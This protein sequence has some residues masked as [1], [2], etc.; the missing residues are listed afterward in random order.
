[1][2]RTLP[3]PL[4]WFRPRSRSELLVSA[5]SITT[6]RDVRIKRA[7]IGLVSL[8]STVNGNEYGNGVTAALAKIVSLTNVGDT[9][10]GSALISEQHREAPS[11][12][13]ADG[14]DSATRASAR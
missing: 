8:I 13:S 6:G 4:D 12:S 10:A 1:M 2:H 7:K 5:F 9:I 3:T 14:A 11:N